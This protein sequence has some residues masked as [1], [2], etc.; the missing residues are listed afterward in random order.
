MVRDSPNGSP[1][2]AMMVARSAFHGECGRTSESDAALYDALSGLVLYP[3][4]RALAQASCALP[5]GAIAGWDLHPLEKYR[6]T[7][8]HTHGGHSGRPLRSGPTTSIKIA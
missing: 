8:A 1:M 4:R 5:A 3:S 6:L 7:T 2:L